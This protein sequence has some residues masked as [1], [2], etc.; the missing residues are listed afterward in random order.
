[1]SDGLFYPFLTY[2][3][4]PQVVFRCVRLTTL[5]ADNIH[6]TFLPPE[7]GALS[8]L[9]NL[10]LGGKFSFVVNIKQIGIKLNWLWLCI[11]FTGHMLE[12]LPAEISK[13][14]VLSKLNLSGVPW[15]TSKDLLTY[16]EY[17]TNMERNQAFCEMTEQ[18]IKDSF[19]SVCFENSQHLY[20][21][22]LPNLS[23]DRH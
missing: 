12:K 11:F 5:C 10:R 2:R 4:I 22:M 15:F 3:N 19:V 18:V 20:R 16:S 7:I 6:L 14:S 1:M 23:T 8:S 9:R 17:L 13:L 21:R